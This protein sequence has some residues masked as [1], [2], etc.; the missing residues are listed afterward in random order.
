M[1]NFTLLAAGI[2]LSATQVYSSTQIYPSE[3]LSTYALNNLEL[4]WNKKL[5]CSKLKKVDEEQSQ[6]NI[7]C[8][9][10]ALKEQ[11]RSLEIDRRQSL[12]DSARA[13]DEARK[14]CSDQA[15]Q[16]W[17]EQA[18]LNCDFVSA[19]ESYNRCVKALN[20]IDSQEGLR[21]SIRNDI[22]ICKEIEARLAKRKPRSSIWRNMPFI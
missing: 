5:I 7:N 16:M 8:A 20:N 17:R 9:S 2:L 18:G 3:P 11:L 21:A 6:E 1:K 4:D 19:G 15:Y 12:V 22:K 13:Q 14:H 10:V